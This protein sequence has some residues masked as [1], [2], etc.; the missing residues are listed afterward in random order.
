MS[1]GKTLDH[2]IGDPLRELQGTR[3]CTTPE[4][5]YAY[6]RGK[7]YDDLQFYVETRFW[8][9]S[10]NTPADEWTPMT[11][12]LARD[13]YGNK[14]QTDCEE[15]CVTRKNVV[16][17][18][19]WGLSKNLCVYGRDAK[20]EPWGHAVCVVWDKKA[21]L[22]MDYTMRRF[23]AGAEITG[24][25]KTLWPSATHYC[26][27]DDSGKAISGVTLLPGVRLTV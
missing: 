15:R 5:L 26:F 1:I 27:R 21:F 13:V 23:P 12:V 25:I 11:A 10:D 4:K 18:L 14:I 9:V 19:G 7:D 17:V 22:V 2:F 24:V 20:G 6:M 16:N 3:R 8:Y